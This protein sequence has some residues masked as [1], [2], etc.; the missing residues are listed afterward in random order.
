MTTGL[1]AK[2]TSTVL[3]SRLP[4]VPLYCS[5]IASCPKANHKALRSRIKH[6][7]APNLPRSFLTASL[8]DRATPSI[9]FGDIRDLE[10]AQVEPVLKHYGLTHL[11]SAAVYAGGESESRLG[12]AG[13]GRRGF[14]IDT[15]IFATRPSDG[16]L[17]ASA[18]EESS[19]RSLQRLGVDHVHTLYAHG[20]DYATPIAE[21]AKAFDDVYRKGRFK[22]L[23]LAN[24]MP[25]YVQQFVATARVNGYIRPTWFQGQY[26]LVVR[27]Y[28]DI[29]FPLLRAKG[30]QFAAYSPLA[31]GFLNGNLTPEGAKGSRFTS[32]GASST[33][34]KSAF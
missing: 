16:T 34:R 23:G 3:H 27:T 30:V 19:A 29:L 9:F 21:Q 18:I 24:C 7:R 6:L 4:A 8:A 25:Q 13:L 26:N 28:E 1:D 17:S 2:M 14:T 33:Y 11:D 12:K 22:E 20:P 32:H 5:A 31:G 15:K 10:I